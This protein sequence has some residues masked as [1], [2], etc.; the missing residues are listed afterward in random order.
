MPVITVEGAPLSFEQKRHLIE[1]LT[2]VAS[3]IME[4]PVE[5]YI[6]LIKE[7]DRDNIG[8]KGTMLSQQTR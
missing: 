6:V 3:V 7:N 2:K 8:L 1:S 5:I 4:V